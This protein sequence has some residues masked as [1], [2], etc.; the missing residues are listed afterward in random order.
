V[1]V[2]GLFARL[3]WCAWTGHDNRAERALLHAIGQAHPALRDDAHYYRSWAPFDPPAL[4]LPR[5]DAL[6]EREAAAGAAANA[7]SLALVAVQVALE[8]D[9]ADA[10]RRALALWPEV[11]QGLHPA[12]P[13]SVACCTLAQAL[14]GAGHEAQAQQAL[15][16]AR[17]WLAG[18]QLPDDSPQAR[19]ALLTGVPAHRS[20]LCDAAG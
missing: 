13:P 7:R 18:V 16:L 6:A 5:L 8:V 12:L 20:W 11:H 15:D 1:R 3:R 10:A 14:R 4:A 19:Q 9:A 17:Q 2:T